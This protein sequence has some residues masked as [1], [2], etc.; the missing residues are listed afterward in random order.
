M[1]AP[2]SLFQTSLLEL[3]PLFSLEAQ[4]MLILGYIIA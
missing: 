4:H 3:W 1:G 2:L